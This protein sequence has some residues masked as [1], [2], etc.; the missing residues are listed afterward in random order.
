[1]S[2]KH[3]IKSGQYHHNFYLP[4]QPNTD[5][6]GYYEPTSL[7]ELEQKGRLYIIA[8]T[9]LGTSAGNL[10]CQYAIRK[11]LHGYYRTTTEADVEKRL[12][13]VIKTTNVEIFKRNQQFPNR[14]NIATTL[15]AA[16]IHQNKLI[17]V[18]VGDSQAYVVWEQSIENLSENV[19]DKPSPNA[20]LGLSEEIEVEI[21]YRRLFPKDNVVLCTG[22]V[23]GYIDEKQIA[24]I[25]AQYPPHEAARRLTQLAYN[26]TCRDNLAVSV[27][28]MLEQS[29]AQVP[30]PRLTMPESP[31]WDK[32]LN[33]PQPKQVSAKPSVPNLSTL[34]V[35][36]ASRQRLWGGLLVMIIILLCLATGFWFGWQYIMPPQTDIAE[37]SLETEADMSSEIS[38]ETSETPDVSEPSQ[39]ETSSIDEAS[40]SVDTNATVTTSFTEADLSTP[41]P[42]NEISLDELTDTLPSPTAI[43][44]TLTI[45]PT[46]TPTVQ[47][48]QNCIS[49]A[50][51][52]D[53]LTIPDG[54]EVVAGQTFE[55]AWSIQNNGTCPW[56]WGYTVRF[57]DGDTMHTLD[58]FPVPLIEPDELTA[59]TASLVAPNQIGTHRSQWQ[60]YDLEGESFGADLYVEIKV[61]PPE[62]GAVIENPNE[63]TI[64]SFIEQVATADWQSDEIIYTPQAG[65]IDS[66]LVITSPLGIVV[67]GIAEL[68]GRRDTVAD[69]LLTHPH[70]ETGIIEGRYAVDTPLKPTDELVV[71]LGFPQAA[72][73]NKDGAIFEVMFIAA[74]GSMKQVLSEKVTYRGGI[75]SQRIQLDSVTSGQTGEFI[76]RVL[77]GD[78]N[79]Y[80]WALWLDARLVR[81]Q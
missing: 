20:G 16:L 30:P 66:D 26:R 75:V 62:P 73:L 67:L 8:D 9:V 19:S 2:E 37:N 54:T 25:V 28:Q 18:N 7:D 23:R 57:V 47:L 45:T 52:F 50:R 22:G 1:M 44:F 78:N 13:E 43:A 63:T 31:T 48:P 81:P 51:F 12:I 76:L 35:S 55:K 5:N 34:P 14:R 56:V 61:V 39:T 68:R 59:I 46:P 27:S 79:A 15:M 21:L 72:I 3:A 58:Q 74:D 40:T 36:P 38:N 4:N 65:R 33:Q 24:D 41:T 70:Q 69:V 17:V 80:D 77:A 53:D 6:I 42:A 60:M 49:G 10:A 64:Y 29:I 11:I 71:S 32:L